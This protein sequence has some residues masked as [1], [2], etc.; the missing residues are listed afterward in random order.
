MSPGWSRMLKVTQK[1]KED[2]TYC[3]SIFQ[4][5]SYCQVSPGNHCLILMKAGWVRLEEGVRRGRR[6][7]LVVRDPVKWESREE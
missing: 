4:Y 1:E 5:T 3:F 7:G 6:H 2:E